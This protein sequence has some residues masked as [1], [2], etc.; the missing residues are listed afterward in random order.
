M[1]KAFLTTPATYELAD[2]AT[3]LLSISVNQAGLERNFSDLKIK[4]TRLRNRLKLP[5]LEKMAKVGADIRSSHKEAGFVEERMKRQNHEQNKVAELL[6]VPRYADLLEHDDIADVNRDEE[7]LSAA[8]RP[9][10]VKSREGWRKEMAKW[11]ED[12]QARINEVNSDAEEEELRNIMYGCQRSKWLPRSL[13]LLFA[14]RKESDVD[15]Q[16][17]RTRR[18]QGYTEEAWLMELLADEE[19]NEDRIPDDGEL[20]GSGDDFDG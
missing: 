10:L 17:R 6:K 5:K 11:V 4:K 15:E 9:G 18:Q 2:F 7:E 20:E 8:P 3:L 12:E 16:V 19:A 1:W 14:G 13:E